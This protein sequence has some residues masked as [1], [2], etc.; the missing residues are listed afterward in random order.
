MRSGSSNDVRLEIDV[1]KH[2][3][4][5]YQNNYKLLGRILLGVLFF[6]FFLM[7]VAPW[8][9]FLVMGAFWLVPFSFGI[10]IGFKER[11]KL[12]DYDSQMVVNEAR[13]L[14]RKFKLSSKMPIRNFEE[15]QIMA[16]PV[17]NQCGIEATGPSVLVRVRHKGDSRHTYPGE[18]SWIIGSFHSMDCVDDAELLAEKVAQECGA[19][20]RNSLAC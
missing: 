20:V 14:G 9:I 1:S 7:L 11:L 5:S 4:V 8:P 19:P 13:W 6:P 12:W 10:N 17:T 18:N 3:I 2:Q 15:V 16:M